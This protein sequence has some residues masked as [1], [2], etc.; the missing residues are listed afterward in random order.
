MA[1]R[2]GGQF[3]TFEGGEGAGKSTQARRLA[4]RFEALGAS[5]LLT[6]EPGGSPQAEV[7]RDQ[8][9]AGPSDRWTPM[10]QLLLMYAARAEHLER[11]IWP[12]LAAR[13]VVIS[14]R[15]AD[16]SMAYQGWAQGLG[17]EAV[18]ALDAIVVRDRAPDLTIILDVPA[19]TGLA[20]AKSRG[21][22]NRFEGMDLSFHEDLRHAYLEIAAAH[23]EPIL[24]RSPDL[25]FY[26]VLAGFGA[27]DHTALG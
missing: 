5:V 12:A 8:L 1:R 25:F 13:Q 4:A 2:A 11:V 21:E 15:F 26:V 9:L 7:I 24:N 6:R 27:H 16:S 14:D 18:N 3:V 20:R 17:V 22:V 10:A 19:K 23:P